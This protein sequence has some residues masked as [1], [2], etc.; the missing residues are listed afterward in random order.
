MQRITIILGIGCLVV[1]CVGGCGSRPGRRS[2]R[3]SL[4]TRPTAA[5]VSATRNGHSSFE[6]PVHSTNGTS[7]LYT[8]WRP[9]AGHEEKQGTLADRCHFSIRRPMVE[10]DGDLHIA[11]VRM[12][13]WI[14]L[15]PPKLSPAWA[16]RTRWYARPPEPES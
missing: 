1:M 6:L 14:A 15:Q 4:L 8:N 2:K 11:H 13:H 3:G 16:N 12:R 9:V 10:L 7:R 5:W